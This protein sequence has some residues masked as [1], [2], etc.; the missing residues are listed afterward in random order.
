MSWLLRS[1]LVTVIVLGLL[2]WG[3]E[4]LIVTDAGASLPVDLS[5]LSKGTADAES[6]NWLI[7][8]NLPLDGNLQGAP[9]VARRDGKLVGI[10][11]VEDSRGQIL[12]WPA[13]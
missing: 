6:P 4:R 3:V 2:I 9:V 7:D 10:L 8:K 5:R 1:K 11:L 13:P 12:P